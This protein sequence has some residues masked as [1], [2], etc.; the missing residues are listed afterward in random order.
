M[1]SGSTVLNIECPA[2]RLRDRACSADARH[3]FGSTEGCRGVA[4]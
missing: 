3:I 1:I 4:H 2:L